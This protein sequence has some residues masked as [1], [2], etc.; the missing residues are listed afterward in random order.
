MASQ[1]ERATT[2]TR[3]LDVAYLDCIQHYVSRRRNDEQRIW[4]GFDVLLGLLIM[5]S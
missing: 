1:S 4:S 2:Y 3:S 5:E